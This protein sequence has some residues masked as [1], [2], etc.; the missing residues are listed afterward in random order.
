MMSKGCWVP[1][2]NDDGSGVFDV[3]S[4]HV[5]RSCMRCVREVRVFLVVAIATRLSSSI[6][7]EFSPPAE[8]TSNRNCLGDGRSSICGCS[9]IK[10]QSCMFAHSVGKGMTFAVSSLWNTCRVL[11][12]CVWCGID[13]VS[14][15]CLFRGMW[16]QCSSVQLMVVISASYSAASDWFRP[17]DCCCNSY[18]SRVGIHPDDQGKR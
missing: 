7:S 12:L 11:C 16:H 5:D 1:G 15:L 10:V 2:V 3:I 14:G 6:A 17:G 13:D 4:D 8:L 18:E 9:K